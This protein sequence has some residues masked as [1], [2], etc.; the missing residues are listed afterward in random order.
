MNFTGRPPRDTKFPPPFYL[1]FKSSSC[2]YCHTC[3]RIINSRQIHQSKTHSSVIKYCSE[4]CRRNK[5]GPLDRL[6]EDAFAALLN[7]KRETFV[8]NYGAD[9]SYGKEERGRKEIEKSSKQKKRTGDQ[10]IIVWCSEVQA[11]VFGHN[12]NQIKH[13]NEEKSPDSTNLINKNERKNQRLRQEY[14]L[15]TTSQTELHVNLE[16]LNIHEQMSSHET[17]YHNCVTNINHH[18]QTSDTLADNC[19]DIEQQEEELV[20]QKENMIQKRNRGQKIAQEREIVRRAARRAVIFG[21]ADKDIC[22][23]EEIKNAKQGRHK[24]K[25]TNILEH[26]DENNSGLE[27]LTGITRLCEAV[28]T[29]AAIVVEPSFA[30]GD[31]GIRWRLQP[32]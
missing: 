9:V 26:K 28:M 13:N 7:D 31:W 10:R 22:A 25:N 20:T 2:I 14:N 16:N 8:K 11:L 23:S 6:V 21:L 30:K 5:P 32:S 4:R 3:G 1:I 15:E 19:C 17:L 24:R 29:E 12:M 27:R 18:S